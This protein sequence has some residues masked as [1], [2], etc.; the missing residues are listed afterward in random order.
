MSFWTENS[1]EPKRAY[2]FRIK[3]GSI[4]L[5]A[6]AGATWWNAKKVD[7][8]SF[9][10][11]SNKYRLINHQ[12]NVPGIVTWNPITIELADVGK[13]VNAILEDLGERGG[14]NPSN[15]SKDKGIAKSYENGILKAFFIE[16]LNGNGD[17]IEKWS[18][19]GVFVSDVKLS[20]LDYG[21]DEIIS[22]TLT[23]T[24]DYAKLE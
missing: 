12:I 18:L 19:E 24:Y 20:S 10:V 4:G 22:A 11:N 15:L 16:Q 8:P 14:Y 9:T 1:L 17:V 21:S 5:G 6:N 7:K 23:L 13:T 2:R 3:G